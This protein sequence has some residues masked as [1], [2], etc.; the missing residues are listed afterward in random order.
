MDDSPSEAAPLSER[1]N[2]EAVIHGLASDLQMLRAG[3]ISLDD[4]RMRA[5]LAK[6]IMNGVRLVINARRSLEAE[7]RLLTAA[8]RAAGE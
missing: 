5:E 7:A 6:Q 4:A 8:S 1:F 3:K 2:I